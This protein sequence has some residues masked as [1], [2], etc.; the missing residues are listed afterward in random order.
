MVT[1]N[2]TERPEEACPPTVRARGSEP[3]ATGNVAVMRESLTHCTGDAADAPRETCADALA[4]GPKLAPE[5]V[6]RAPENPARGVTSSMRGAV[7]EMG[8]VAAGDW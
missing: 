8:I 1:V 5:M 6:K 4:E 3:E 2:D 7:Y